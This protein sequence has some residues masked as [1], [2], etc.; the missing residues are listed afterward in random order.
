[1]GSGI[2]KKCSPISLARPSASDQ[3]IRAPSRRSGEEDRAWARI[4][5]NATKKEARF[6]SHKKHGRNISRSLSR[7]SGCT[8][9]PPLSQEWRNKIKGAIETKIGSR[10][11]VFGI[12]LRN[13]LKGYRKLRVGDYRVIF[14]VE[15]TTIKIYAIAIAR[16]YTKCPRNEFDDGYTEVGP[17]WYI[18]R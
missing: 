18:A 14:R 10:P 11:E 6:A 16:A 1:M 2:L 12:P 9:H 3:G 8:R 4:A 5:E 13:T 7:T 15:S 17:P